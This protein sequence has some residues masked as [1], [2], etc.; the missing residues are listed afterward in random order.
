MKYVV[1]KDEKSQIDTNILFTAEK[2][3]WQFFNSQIEYPTKRFIQFVKKK[4]I[5]L[6]KYIQLQE[7]PKEKTN[8]VFNPKK[9]NSETQH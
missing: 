9:F 3:T 8:R 4:G 7:R 2:N 1:K 5:L 6:K